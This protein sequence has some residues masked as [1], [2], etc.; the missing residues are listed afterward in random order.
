MRFMILA[1]GMLKHEDHKLETSQSYHRIQG[2][3]GLQQQKRNKSLGTNKYTEYS[4]TIKL[5][6]I[7]LPTLLTLGHSETNYFIHNY[8]ENTN[9]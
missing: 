4:H 9:Q 2:R 1:F 5:P 8:P 7:P 6:I 3:P